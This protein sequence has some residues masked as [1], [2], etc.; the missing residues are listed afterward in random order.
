MSGSQSTDDPMDTDSPVDAE[1]REGEDDVVWEQF[2]DTGAA[3]LWKLN[4]SFNDT[5]I[6]RREQEFR[7]YVQ[8]QVAWDAKSKDAISAL[9]QVK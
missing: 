1:D 4:P 9:S 5:C 8:V 6:S 7:E 3:F 2:E